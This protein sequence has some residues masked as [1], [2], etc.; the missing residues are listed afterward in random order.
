MTESKVRASSLIV[1]PRFYPRAGGIDRVHC[2]HLQLAIR[3][4]EEIPPIIVSD[5]G[6]LVDGAHRKAAYEAEFGPDAEI[7]A[8]VKHYPDEAAMIEDAVRI[9]VRHGKPLCPQDLTHAAQL[10]RSYRVQ[11][12]PHLARLFGRTVEY[13]QRIVVREARTQ[14]E[15]G[16]EPQVIPVKYAV[17][18]L[19]GEEISEQ[20]ADAQRMVIGSPLTFQ[21]K[22]LRS[23]LDN[24][25]VPTTNKEL[26]R[27]LRLLYRSL[28]N[29]LSQIKTTRKRKEPV[30]S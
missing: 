1:D 25:L 9:N 11:D 15:N 26:I 10:L 2:Y 4:G 7:P 28:G 30:E 12:I 23:A 24:G 5:T 29:F 17:R 13:T 16:G 21:A 18:H 22:Q 19:A 6:I 27:E 14:P 3:A 20:Q 8:I